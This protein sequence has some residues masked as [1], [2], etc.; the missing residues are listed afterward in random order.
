MEDF[1]Y[2]Y[3]R[4]SLKEVL[5]LIYHSAIDTD[6]KAAIKEIVDIVKGRSLTWIPPIPR[7]VFKQ[8]GQKKNK[9][10]LKKIARIVES[11]KLSYKL[12]N[13]VRAKGLED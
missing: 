2:T 3:S 12:E 8:S 7:R 6:N 11:K 5:K 10:Y 9:R 1:G 13:H 4:T